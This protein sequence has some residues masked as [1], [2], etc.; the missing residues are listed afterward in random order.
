MN[1]KFRTFLSNHAKNNLVV[2]PKGVTYVEKESLFPL[3][4]EVKVIRINLEGGKKNKRRW[5]NAGSW[6]WSYD[7]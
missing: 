5:Y 6:Y 2:Y 4:K 3:K 1:F 7:I